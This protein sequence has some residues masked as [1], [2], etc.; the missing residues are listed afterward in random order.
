VLDSKFSTHEVLQMAT[1]LNAYSEYPLASAFLEAANDANIEL[2]EAKQVISTSG[3]GI[4][5]TIKNKSIQLGN[6]RFIKPRKEIHT[7]DQNKS[8]SWLKVENDVIGYFSITDKI[9]PLAYN[10]INN[11]LEKNI[12][13]VM[14]FGDQESVVSD[15]AHQLGI[16]EHQSKCL[17]IDKLDKVIQLQEAGFTVA[18]AGVETN[19]APVLAQANIGIATDSGTDIAIESADITLLHGDISAIHKAITVSKSVMRNI[20]QNLFFALIYNVR[21]VSIVAGLLYLFLGAL[22]SPMVAAMAMSISSV[23]VI[24]NSLRLKSVS[25]ID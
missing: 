18:V 14:L 23:S 10:A 22:L 2:L 4:Q 21:G 6:D 7:K 8:I 9:K 1:S 19:D 11:I 12:P 16:K 17:P 3:E 13:V 24:G 5:G 25:L 20:K 15:M